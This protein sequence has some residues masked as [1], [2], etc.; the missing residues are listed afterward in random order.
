MTVNNKG[1]LAATYNDE[2]NTQRTC[3]RQLVPLPQKIPK[4]TTN[5]PN[6]VVADYQNFNIPPYSGAPRDLSIA[7][8]I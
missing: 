8:C 1:R 5:I 7:I 6:V 4:P 3:M 2:D